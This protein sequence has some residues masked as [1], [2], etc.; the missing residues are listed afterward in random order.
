MRAR[1]GDR[2]PVLVETTLLRRRAAA[3]FAEL[4]TFGL[5]VHRR[6]AAAGH[7]G[8]R[9][10]RT[11]PAG[12]PGAAVHDV[13]LLDRHRAGRAASTAAGFV[14]GSDIDPVRLAM[15][16]PQPAAMSAA[17]PRR[18]AAPG[19][20]RRRR[21]SPTRRAA[22]AGG[23]GSTRATTPAAGRA[24]RRLP[25]PGSRREVRAGNRFRLQLGRLGF[26]G[27]IEVTSLAGSVREACLWSAGLA[28]PGVRRR[29]TMSRPR[30]TDHRRR[31]RRLPGAARRAAGSSTPTARWCAPGWCATTPPG[32]GCGSSTPTSPT[33]PVTGCPPACAASRCSTSWRS[34]SGGCARRCR[35]TTAGAVEILVRGVDVDPDALRRRLRLR[36]SAAAVGGDHPHR[37]RAR[38]VGRWRSSADPRGEGTSLPPVSL[39]AAARCRSGSRRISTM[40]IPTSV[41]AATAAAL[42]VSPA[43]SSRHRRRPRRRCAGSRRSRRRR[44]I[45]HDP[46]TAT[47][48]TRCDITFPANYPDEQAA[49]RLRQTEPGRLRQRRE[50]ARLARPAL[51]AGGHHRPSTAPAVPPQ[52]HAVGGVQVL[53]GCRRGAPAD[54]VQGVQ[55]DNLALAQRPD[56]LRDHRCS[57]PGTKPLD[58]HLPDRAAP[59]C[60][61]AVRR[62]AGDRARGGP[63]PGAPTRTSPSPTTR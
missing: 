10:P 40:R 21:R 49:D 55:L 41:L 22:A 11:G 38:Q 29:A 58:D 3:K 47:P 46:A 14:V 50:D 25:R 1:F 28:E 32:T 39:T 36:A 19:H 33:C 61:E 37:L 5:A 17:V 51:P 4:A 6:R 35:R 15:A 20:P 57:Q 18:R 42:S 26:D 13:D 27:E 48:S 23:D 59:N 9:W 52:G 34:A 56:H 8:S 62:Q 2:A 44:Q 7:R 16:Q 12:W 63:G 24:A 53:P 43:S 54:L 30:R 45:C 31:T 60:D